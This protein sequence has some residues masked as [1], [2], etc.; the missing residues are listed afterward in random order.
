MN[1]CDTGDPFNLS[2]NANVNFTPVPYFLQGVHNGHLEMHSCFAD[3][4]FLLFGGL[5]IS[6]K[7]N[8]KH[9]S[10][11]EGLWSITVCLNYYF[12][13]QTKRIS[14]P[15][16]MLEIAVCW[17]VLKIISRT[18]NCTIMLFIWLLKHAKGNSVWLTTE[19][20]ASSFHLP[21]LLLV[22]FYFSWLLLYSLYF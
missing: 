15:S 21:P 9:V 17:F 13:I 19:W 11:A 3:Q 16:W 22:N 14:F 2:I 8:S 12:H 20:R 4:V 10:G 6:L 7:L 5:K 1:P 18:C